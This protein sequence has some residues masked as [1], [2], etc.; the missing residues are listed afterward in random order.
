M[1]TNVTTITLTAIF[2]CLAVSAF[3]Q[4][5][6][7]GTGQILDPAVVPSA[8]GGLRSARTVCVSPFPEDKGRIFY[9]G[10]LDAAQ[11]PHRDTAWIYKGVL[12]QTSRE[13]P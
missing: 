7:G 13:N 12:L 10:G 1:K 5:R 4:Q 8:V 6:P 3:T 2:A 9:F 11:G